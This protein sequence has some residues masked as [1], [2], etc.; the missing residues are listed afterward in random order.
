MSKFKGSNNLDDI[1]SSAGSAGIGEG[2]GKKNAQNKT[3]SSAKCK[4]AYDFSVNRNAA[5][6][7]KENCQNSARSGH[8]TKAN[9]G[10]SESK[11]SKPG[12]IGVLLV[13]SV[14]IAM[15]IGG[16]SVI[17]S[18]RSSDSLQSVID[19]HNYSSIPH[20]KAL[21]KS[22][23]TGSTEEFGVRLSK[24]VNE[25]GHVVYDAAWSDGYWSSYV[26]WSDGQVEIFSKNGNDE[27]ER[28]FGR[29]RHNSKGD[30]VVHA[31]TDAITI[32]PSLDPAVNSI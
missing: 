7:A 3:P 24:R 25:N 29:F 14:S 2:R 16:V 21:F 8:Y 11:T 10:Y 15:F 9:A 6:S 18:H 17:S 4:S 13:A 23:R 30:C 5:K 19:I 32:F 28:T 26:Y 27:I 22:A 12:G 1:A 31:S 20:G